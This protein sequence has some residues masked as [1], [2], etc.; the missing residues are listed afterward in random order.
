[1]DTTKE[2]KLWEYK[3]NKFKEK[4]QEE[5]QN[6]SENEAFMRVCGKEH[7]GYVRGMGLG[8]SSSQIIGFS[9][10]ASSSTTS[11]ESNEM[12]EQMQSEIESLKA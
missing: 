10:S 8:V 2:S 1:M 6:C 5:M 4:L 11:F 12:M 7:P 9:S 3:E